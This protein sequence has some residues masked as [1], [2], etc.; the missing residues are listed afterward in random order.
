MRRQV[1][2]VEMKDGARSWDVYRRYTEFC[3]LHAALKK[4][5]I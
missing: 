4:Q 1:Y 3:R 5:V 2:H